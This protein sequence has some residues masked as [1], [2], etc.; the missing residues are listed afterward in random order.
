ME[1][2]N[3]NYEAFLEWVTCD[4]QGEFLL[5]DDE[6][7]LLSHKISLKKEHGECY[8]VDVDGVRVIVFNHKPYELI[9]QTTLIIRTLD[10]A[11][12]SYK[13]IKE[14]AKQ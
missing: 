11:E 10:T 7:Y 12:T 2:K 9:E 1:V 8:T 3:G 13:F 4:K 14:I 6:V 5:C